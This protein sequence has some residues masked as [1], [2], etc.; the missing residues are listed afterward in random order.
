[1]RIAS[2][3]A[4]MLFIGALHGCAFTTETIDINYLPEPGVSK[5]AGAESV[6]VAVEVT[7]SRQDR[8][9]VSS[10]K[11]GYGMETAPILA[12]EDVAATV[13]RA[14][15]EE[16]RA[17]GYQSA[18]AQADVQ[19]NA[20]V[21]RFYNDHKLGFFS[22]DAVAD[23]NMTIKVVGAANRELFSRTIA[24]EGKEA[25]TQ[26]AT[27]ANAKRAL[28]KAL[29]NGMRTLFADPAFIAALS[30]HAKATVSTDKTGHLL[31]ELAADKTLSPE[32]YKRRYEIIRRNQ[33]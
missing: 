7:D 28:D 21:T 6:A 29:A 17:R 32:E 2:K 31:E 15:T 24:S 19:V 26:L 25:N 5:V 20:L 16:I 23:F 9:R 4:L 1:M 10:K 30:S 18:T 33:N 11:N 8:S 22:G 13:R 12:N 14:L 3:L 27:G